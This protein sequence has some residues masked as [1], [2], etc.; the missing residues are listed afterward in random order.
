MRYG[1]LA[2]V[3]K[4]PHPTVEAYIDVVV[5]L[6]ASLFYIGGENIAPST[7]NTISD[8]LKNR[9]APHVLF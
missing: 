6:I 5:L 4:N 7:S 2:L 1:D 9:Y 8:K 3:P